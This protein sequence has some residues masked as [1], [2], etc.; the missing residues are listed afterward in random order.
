MLRSCCS[1]MWNSWLSYWWLFCFFLP[2][3]VVR[4]HCKDEG[5]PFKHH[6][7]LLCGAKQFVYVLWFMVLLGFIPMWCVGTSLICDSSLLRYASNWVGCPVCGMWSTCRPWGWEWRQMAKS[8]AWAVVCPRKGEE[9]H[10]PLWLPNSTGVYGGVFSMVLLWAVPS[11]SPVL[12]PQCVQKT[13]SVLGPRDAHCEYLFVWLW[14]LACTAHCWKN[15][16]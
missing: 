8:S 12:H 5:A 9:G 4:C 10:W 13:Q 16:L 3:E 1:M 2:L 14:C 15:N 6:R 11:T 7:M